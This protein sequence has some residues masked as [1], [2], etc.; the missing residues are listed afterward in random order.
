M[1]IAKNKEAFSAQGIPLKRLRIPHI[2][3]RPHEAALCRIGFTG[4][5]PT[6][7][8]QK[9]HVES[10]EPSASSGPSAQTPMQ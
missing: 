7:Q 4:T 3:K 6:S 10:M 8:G 1:E 2:H 9:H 5:P